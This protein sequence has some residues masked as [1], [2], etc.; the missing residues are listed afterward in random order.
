MTVL[1]LGEDNLN[2]EKHGLGAK[3]HIPTHRDETAMNGAPDLLRLIEENRA[4]A[5]ANASGFFATS[6]Q[7]DKS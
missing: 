4:K 7:N 1:C 5:N 6:A 2:G 3:L